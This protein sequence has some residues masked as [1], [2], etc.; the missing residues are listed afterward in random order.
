M[1]PC[2]V[3]EYIILILSIK[4]FCGK[5]CKVECNDR[6]Y[7]FEKEIWEAS[8]PENNLIN[9]IHNECPDIY[10]EHIPQMNLIDFFCNF[11]GLLGM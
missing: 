9:I 1:I 7:S 6:Y 2:Y 5:L 11:G 10:V 3:N 4:S 8:D